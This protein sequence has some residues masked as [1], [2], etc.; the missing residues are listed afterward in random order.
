[1]KFILSS[2]KNGKARFVLLGLF[3]S[4]LVIGVLLMYS[5]WAGHVVRTSAQGTS[6][7][8][9]EDVTFFYNITINNTDALV[10]ANITQVN[11]TLPSGFTFAVGSNETDA[12]THTFSNTSN[13]LTWS[14]NGLVINLTLK[15]FSFNATAVTPGNYNITVATLN[16]TTVLYSNVSVV[17]NDTTAPSSVT[18]VSPTD[19]DGANVSRSH[20]F[21]N[22][23]AADGVSIQAIVVRLFNSSRAQINLSNS[24]TSPLS[25]NF[26]S[27]GNG[28]YYMNA[29]VNDTAGN[30]NSTPTR[31]V[32][33]DTVA[34]IVFNSNIS[35]PISGGNYSNVIGNVVLNVSLV[36]AT[37]AVAVLFFNITN[38]AGVQNATY[39]ATREGSTNYY[40]TSLNTTGFSDGY[41]NVTV[42]V[43][44]S[45]GN[46]NNSALASRI[47][48]DNTAP[49]ASLS[50]TPSSVQ[51]GG[52]VACSCTT[53]DLTV[54]VLSTVY[55][56]NPSTASTGTFSTSCTAT[57]YSNNTVSSSASYTVESGGS[58]GGGGGGGGA[59]SGWVTFTVDDSR[60]SEGYTKELSKNQ[61]LK[62][63][64]NRQEHFV[65]VT[66]LFA[67]SARIQVSSVV[68]TATLNVGETKK[69]E[70]SEDKY[71]DISATLNRISGNKAG[72]TIK[73]INERVPDAV[74]S[75][76]K[77]ETNTETESAPLL[78]PEEASASSGERVIWMIVVSVILLVIVGVGWFMIKKRY[79]R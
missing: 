26:S 76:P 20:I 16:A 37:S 28:V 60:F 54:G 61:R 46:V 53:S 66:D 22:I 69:F 59:G 35:S 62:V 23:T 72:I 8:I 15:Y 10:D 24:A 55:T 19:A 2:E 4:C 6:Y 44:D 14:N 63:S 41:Y 58:S 34:P 57:D 65:G 36:D 68:Q 5:V 12:G 18:F 3:I 56:A 73:L 50:C 9:N 64:V 13:V 43:N 52:V 33:V 71:Y 42:W 39:T 40:S 75:V 17:V 1:M 30:S 78:A 49:S 29:T 7:Y 51:V 74:P 47:G 70:V 67:S 11:M 31:T 77:T 38:S 79:R 27:L 32:T 25:G 21:F 48:F 45:A